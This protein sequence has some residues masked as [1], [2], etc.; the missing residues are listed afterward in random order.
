[1][2]DEL[3]QLMMR[4]KLCYEIPNRPGNYIAPQLLDVEAPLKLE[5]EEREDGEE[6]E[7]R[8]YWWDSS[9]NLILRYKYEF[10]PKGIITRFIVETHDL[11]EEQKL[12]WRSG[13]VLKKDEA[14]AEVIENYNQREIKVRVSGKQKKE[15]LA[16]INRELG[17]IH[18]SFERLEYQ[19]LVPCN[20]QKC[21]VSKE[22]HSYSLEI[23]RRFLNNNIYN[24]RCENSF[25]EVDVRRLIDD[26]NLS[27]QR[28]DWK[29]N[30]RYVQPKPRPTKNRGQI[31]EELSKAILNAYPTKVKL[32]MMVRY[33]LNQNLA[34]I[35]TGESMEEIVFELIEWAESKGR[36]NELA[37][38][39]LEHNPGNQELQKICEEMNL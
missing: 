13:V 16:I 11:I 4:F 33:K 22:P 19:T 6:G 24:T 2:Q 37:K 32:K 39:A 25:K 5:G 23:L 20:C 18:N 26:V 7:T 38:A 27:S 29:S 14:R 3:L 17:K 30:V 21:V 34:S 8:R 15:L 28:D 31:L 10:M 12:V 35:T 1:M 9:N 36:L